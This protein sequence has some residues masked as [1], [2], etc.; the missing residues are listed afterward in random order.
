MDHLLE[1][2]HRF[3]D[4]AWREYQR[5]FETLADNGQRP[6]ALVI[7]CADSRVD[8]SMIFD[9]GPGDIFTVRNVANLVPPYQPD[10]ALHGTSAAVEFAVRS[11]DVPNLI[12]MGHAMCGGIAALLSEGPQG[13]QA[14]T[15][16]FVGP[17]IRIAAPARNRVLRCAPA[18][19]QLACEHEA[20]RVSL[21]NLMSFPFVAERVLD[22]RLKLHGAHFDIR[23]GVLTVLDRTGEFRPG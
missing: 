18:D 3:R 4:T 8:P 11:L 17:W 16:E 7:A 1:G 19:P 21:D 5:Q 20:V 2:Y 22:G 15:G 14:T 12:V 13:G 10:D 6:R 9:A 23:T